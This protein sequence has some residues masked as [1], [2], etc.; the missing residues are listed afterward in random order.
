MSAALARF[1]EERLGE[2]FERVQIANTEPLNLREP[3]SGT[4]RRFALALDPC[5]ETSVEL[6]FRVMFQATPFRNVTFRRKGAISRVSA[7]KG[8]APSPL[9]VNN[10]FEGAST[11]PPK[12]MPGDGARRPKRRSG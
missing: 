8:G 12:G 11:P 6:K 5:E 4:I 10:E 9:G 1:E 3:F 7:V 2:V